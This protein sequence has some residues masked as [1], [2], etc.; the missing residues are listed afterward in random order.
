ETL[1][2]RERPRVLFAGQISGIEGYTEAMATG[3][4]AGINAARLVLGMESIKPPR[5]SATGSLTH[6]LANANAKNFQPANTTFALLP[7]L[8][9]E[10]RGRSRRNDRRRMQVERGLSDFC[11]WLTEHGERVADGEQKSR[12]EAGH[13]SR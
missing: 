10:P 3:M 7:P 6:Y 4:I 13:N 2:L 12:T 8:E 1:Q 5:A 11:G 9:E